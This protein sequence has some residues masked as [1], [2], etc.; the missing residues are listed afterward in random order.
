MA[1]RNS[2]LSQLMAERNTQLM[3]EYEFTRTKKYNSTTVGC[4]DLRISLSRAKFHEEADLDVHSAVGPPKPHHI[5][6]NLTFRS[7]NFVKKFFRRRTIESCKSSETRVAEVSRR[8]ERCERCKRTF[9]VRRRRR[10]SEPRAGVN[11]AS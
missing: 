8:S 9:E 3:A 1:E 4:T 5:D 6:E 7:E 2:Q 11:H 10:P